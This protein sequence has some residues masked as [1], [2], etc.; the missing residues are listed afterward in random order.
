MNPPPQKSGNTTAT[1][2]GN[3]IENGERVLVSNLNVTTPAK[4]PMANITCMDDDEIDSDGRGTFTLQTLGKSE[5]KDN[6]FCER[7]SMAQIFALLW[8][9][10]IGDPEI[11][12]NITQRIIYGNADGC[13]AVILWNSP[14]NLIEDGVHY[15]VLRHVNRTNISEYE[16]NETLA[17]YSVCICSGSQNISVTAINRCGGKGQTP[18]MAVTLDQKCSA[19]T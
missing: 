1:L 12:Q 10:I 4:F 11:P 3:T 17:V 13:V 19:I 14:A 15:K 7:C 16:G 2:I 5:M 6:A 9:F 8:Y 18:N